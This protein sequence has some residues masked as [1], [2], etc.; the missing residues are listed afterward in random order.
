MLPID[1]QY[2]LPT[3]SPSF[4]S[5]DHG[6]PTRAQQI[7]APEPKK[8]QE[9]TPVLAVMAAHPRSADFGSGAK[10]YQEGTPDARG[11]GYSP[12]LS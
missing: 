4:M 5:G 3:L 9:G 8:Y 7:L 12:A 11:H 6:L 1:V 10:K 2:P